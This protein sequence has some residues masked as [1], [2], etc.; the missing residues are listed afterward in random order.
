MVKEPDVSATAALITQSWKVG[1]RTVT[2]TVPRPVPG[3]VLH[4]ACEWDPDVPTRLTDAEWVE[5]RDGR[6]AA[7]TEIAET[8][9]INV[10]VLD[11]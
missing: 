1:Q 6:Q 2:M 5:Y 7:L 9:R 4:V 11:V 10:G 3:Q 8:L